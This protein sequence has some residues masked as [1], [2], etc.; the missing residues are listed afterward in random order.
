[1][2][3]ICFELERTHL[4]CLILDFAHY[5]ELMHLEEISNSKLHISL[6][7]ELKKTIGGLYLHRHEWELL[8]LYLDP[9]LPNDRV[10]V[11]PTF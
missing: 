11:L 1:L 8:L 6:K 10:G 9:T 7:I 4:V 2:H 3:D 5:H